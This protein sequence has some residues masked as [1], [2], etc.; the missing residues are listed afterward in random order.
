MLLLYNFIISQQFDSPLVI[1]TDDQGVAIKHST[2]SS[3][4]S[5][6]RITHLLKYIMEI[7][8]S[9]KCLDSEHLAQLHS[10]PS[11]LQVSCCNHNQTLLFGAF[12]VH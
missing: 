4:I 2:Q 7:Y 1:F 9:L 6:M 12:S 11:T 5:M 3:I 8:T 10:L